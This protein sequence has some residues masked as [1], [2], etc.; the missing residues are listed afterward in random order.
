M[1][2]ISFKAFIEASEKE[3]RD[4][5][6]RMQQAVQKPDQAKQIARN[7][8]VAAN[9]PEYQDLMAQSPTVGYFANNVVSDVTGL[10]NQVLAKLNIVPPEVASILIKNPNQQIKT[11]N[12]DLNKLIKTLQ[13]KKYIN[14]KQVRNTLVKIARTAPPQQANPP[15]IA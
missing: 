10:T 6:V 7:L 13:D 12:Y 1:N 11:K 9:T 15:A 3:V 5:A 4:L 8:R 14:N 2:N